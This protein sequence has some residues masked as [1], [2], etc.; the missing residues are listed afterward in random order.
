MPSAYNYILTQDRFTISNFVWATFMS[1]LTSIVSKRIK[2]RSKRLKYT[3]HT[4]VLQNPV[5]IRSKNNAKFYYLYLYG[6]EYSD[7]CKSP[8]YFHSN[9]LYLYKHKYRIS[10]HHPRYKHHQKIS[11]RVTPPCCTIL[12]TKIHIYA[13]VHKI[14]PRKPDI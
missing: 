5:H 3:V 4:I 13:L 9:L 10:V 14:L 2:V 8:T 7:C 12:H 1:Q 6:R 11:P